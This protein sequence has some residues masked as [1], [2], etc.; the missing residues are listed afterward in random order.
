MDPPPTAV[1]APIAPTTTTTTG[2][3]GSVVIDLPE[4]DPVSVQRIWNK[5]EGSDSSQADPVP[6]PNSKGPPKLRRRRPLAPVQVIERHY[7]H[8][9]VHPDA[10]SAVAA[11]IP[12][13]EGPVGD[14]LAV[15]PPTTMPVEHGF[16][17]T[18]R[19]LVYASAPA[20]EVWG[21]GSIPAPL[22]V[23][24]TWANP[25]SQMSFMQP[26]TQNNCTWIWGWILCCPALFCCCVIWLVLFGVIEWTDIFGNPW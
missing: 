22:P 8:H 21:P 4:T 20:N 25:V 11:S 9:H 24:G 10:T 26:T 7:H 18:D 6:G 16:V 19:N 5:T 14:P 12:L 3:R 15:V 23:G 1:A 13:G 2:D 17:P